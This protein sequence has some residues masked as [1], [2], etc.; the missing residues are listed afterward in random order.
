ML[1]KG[2]LILLF[3][4]V[5]CGVKA[6][7]EKLLFQ[8]DSVL[9]ITIKIPLDEVLS[10]FKDRPYH[11]AKLSYKQSDGSIFKNKV[12]VKIRGH[13]RAQSSVCTF[14]PLKI[15]FKKKK[16][17]NS[18]FEGQNKIKLVTHCNKN[19]NAEQLILKEYLIYKM[20]QKVSP[21]S[22]KVRL[23]E[24][25]YID[26]TNEGNQS[27]HYG[28]F[29]EDIEDLAERNG[30]VVFEDSIANQEFCDRAAIDKLTV[31][32]FM[33]G[34]LDWSVPFR[35][36]MKLISS[37]STI[38]PIPVP[39]D[40]DYAGFVGAAYAEPPVEFGL[41]SVKERFFMGFCRPVGGYDETTSFF[42]KERVEIIEVVEDAPFI[43]ERTKKEATKYLE[44]F[45]DLLGKPK[46]V[47][48]KLIKACR[49]DH[50]HVYQYETQK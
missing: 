29:I 44:G 50:K 12:T 4:S 27:I 22:F 6:Q 25:T 10:N 14:P 8:S 43:N 5:V 9:K 11:E 23:C 36:N 1:K 24:I 15:N 40:F 20:Y 18:I 32:Q 13:N 30:M 7:T 47:E 16:T 2:I 21:Y 46:Q 45:Y 35:H 38:R 17:T 48:N 28:F 26:V 49:V 33:I 41:S 31:F 34:N 39:Y 37:S 42:R 3:V 19:K